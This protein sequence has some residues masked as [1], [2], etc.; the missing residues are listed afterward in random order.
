VVEEIDVGSSGVEVMGVRRGF[1]L[2]SAVSSSAEPT[3]ALVKVVGDRRGFVLSTDREVGGEDVEE[4]I[5]VGSGGVEVVGDRRRFVLPSVVSS[6]APTVALVKV[7]GDRR[8]N[9][10]VQIIRAQVQKQSPK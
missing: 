6:S 1:V 8:C 10:T 5:N 3:A 4:E 9:R 7:V 2:P